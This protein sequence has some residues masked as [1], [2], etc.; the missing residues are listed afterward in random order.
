MAIR[1]ATDIG[2][3]FTDLVYLDEATGQVGLAKASTTPDNFAQGVLD[4]LRKADFDPAEVTYFVHGTTIVINA[5]TERKGV[6]TGLIT[7]RG[8]R[9]VLEIGRANRPDIYN[10][11]FKKPESFVP[12][13]LR[14]EVA[15]RLD[16]TGRVMTPLN[17]AEV[18]AAVHQL[19]G[20]GVEA[21]A[22]C[23]LH[24]YANPVHEIR[25]AE[26]IKREWP[27]VF[28]SVSHEISKEWREYERTST[29][30]LNAYVKPIAAR[31]LESLEGEL[32]EEKLRSDLHIMKSNGGTSTFGAAQ[33]VPIHLVES[34]PVGGV[35]GAAIVGELIGIPNLI[36]LD[37]GGTTAKTSLIEGGRVK[38]TTDYKI[39]WTPRFPG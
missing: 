1:V 35:I 13:H 28:V 11:M 9:D 21:V 15:E 32:R 23:Y 10:L 5:L 12:R 14:L 22:V 33:E 36:T 26:I 29:A 34:G 2:G 37:I 4:A 6:K 17:E 31:Y 27:E 7:T 16:S 39:Q 38:I 19:R 8:F 24:A 18:V 20:E 30:V 25:T 3:T